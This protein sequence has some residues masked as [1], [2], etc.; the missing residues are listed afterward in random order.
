[1]EQGP[2]R[3]RAM[4]VVPRRKL[5]LYAGRS[6]PLL[7]EDIAGHLGVRLG[8]ANLATDADIERLREVQPVHLAERLGYTTEPDEWGQHPERLGAFVNSVCNNVLLEYYR[9]S[10]RHDQWG[11]AHRARSGSDD[12]DA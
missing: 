10:T 11:G 12:G 3:R 6:H 4:E 5:E 8:N 7:A 2:R 1:M 9:S